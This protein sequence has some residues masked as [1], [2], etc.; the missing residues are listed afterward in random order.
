MGLS[1]QEKDVASRLAVP[2]PVSPSGVVGG[3]ESWASRSLVPSWLR[4][5]ALGSGCVSEHPPPNN[6]LQADWNRTRLFDSLS[7]ISPFCRSD[8]LRAVP[9]AERER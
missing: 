4:A 9:A 5:R 2:F 3:A 8:T 1:E 6:A 7:W